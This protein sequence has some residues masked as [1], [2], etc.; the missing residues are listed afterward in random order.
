MWKSR[1]CARVKGIASAVVLL[2]DNRTFKRG[3]SWKKARFLEPALKGA[4]DMHSRTFL[5]LIL[6]P[7]CHDLRSFLH[8]SAP[9]ND[10]TASEENDA[11]GSWEE[12]SEFSW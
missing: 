7:G 12:T 3:V 1:D 5:S 10:T 9:H 11:R 6:L 2:V 8:S 4:T